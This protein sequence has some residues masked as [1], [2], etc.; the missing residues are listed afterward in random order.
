VYQYKK[1]GNMTCPFSPLT[2]KQLKFVMHYVEFQNATEAYRHAYNTRGMS[3][4]SIWREA[5]RLKKHP[6]VTPWLERLGKQRER[7][8]EEMMKR[9]KCDHESQF[10]KL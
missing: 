2:A 1:R 3:D 6:K 8:R 7:I 4:A 10:A 5:H 9:Y